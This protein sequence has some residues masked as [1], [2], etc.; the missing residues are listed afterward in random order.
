MADTGP[1][2]HRLAAD[3]ILVLHLLFIVTVVLG[4]LL[5]LRWPKLAWIHLPV[6]AWG[7]LVEIT[8]WICPLTPLEQR[9]RLVAGE[10]G[11]SGGFIEHYLVPLIYPAG[12]TTGTRFFY[13]ALVLSTN[14]AVY[15]YLWRDSGRRSGGSR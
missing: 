8:G 5:V 11:Y 13:A 9:L 12:M 14:L 6:V 15:L 1:M 10:D 7:L 4:G 3:T 2:I